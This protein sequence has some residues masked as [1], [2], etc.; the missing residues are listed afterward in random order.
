M[1]LKASQHLVNLNYSTALHANEQ[2]EMSNFQEFFVQFVR[3]KQGMRWWIDR[4]KVL[5]N[6]ILLIGVDPVKQDAILGERKA[7]FDQ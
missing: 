5:D 3:H 4:D 1:G 2:G 6:L 7:R